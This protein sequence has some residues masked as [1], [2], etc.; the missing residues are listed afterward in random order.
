MEEVEGEGEGRGEDIGELEGDQLDSVVSVSV[1]ELLRLPFPLKDLDRWLG[2]ES[3]WFD[4]L[5]GMEEEL[6]GPSISSCFLKALISSKNSSGGA[7]N[8]SFGSIAS[9]G[10]LVTS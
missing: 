8:S 1:I 7:G 10:S 3:K 5:E 2:M 9:P 6:R 4:I